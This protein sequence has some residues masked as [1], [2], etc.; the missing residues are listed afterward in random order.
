M[1]RLHNLTSHIHFVQKCNNAKKA[2]NFFWGV[3][4]HVCQWYWLGTELCENINQLLPSWHGRCARMLRK[5]QVHDHSTT[6][7]TELWP[8]GP[9]LWNVASWWSYYT[10][11]WT[12]L[13]F[14]KPKQGPNAG[15]H[16]CNIKNIFLAYVF[17]SHYY[18]SN[19]FSNSSTYK[20]PMA[21]QRYLYKASI[22][23]HF[24]FLTSNLN[25]HVILRIKIFFC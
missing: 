5:Y 10:V 25:R 13:C 21:V 4:K 20:D 6:L 2:E 14:R 24:T 16:N 23:R 15:V 17:S 1:A 9:N 3:A 7:D 18:W 12:N 11:S 22:F 19:L 8:N